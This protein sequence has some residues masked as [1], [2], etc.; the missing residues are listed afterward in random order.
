VWTLQSPKTALLTSVVVLFCTVAFVALSP[1]PKTARGP[2]AAAVACAQDGAPAPKTARLVALSPAPKTDRLVSSA[3]APPTKH[4]LI[5]SMIMMSTPP[6]PRGP[7]TLPAGPRETT[8]PHGSAPPVQALV[9]RAL[10]KSMVNQT[11][12]ALTAMAPKRSAPVPLK[13][14]Q[15]SFVVKVRV[16][17]LRP[18]PSVWAAAE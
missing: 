10:Q 2:G 4:V 13:V 16:A 9:A 14:Y 1:A 12:L 17:S 11:T 6:T 3:L 18:C 8:P 7:T 5:F 15:A